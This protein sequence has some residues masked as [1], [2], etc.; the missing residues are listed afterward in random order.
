MRLLLTASRHYSTNGNGNVGRVYGNYNLE[1]HP[2]H[3]KDK[4]LY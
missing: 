2:M 3:L 1:I 4:Q